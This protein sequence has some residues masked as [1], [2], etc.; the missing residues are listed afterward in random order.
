LEL[1]KKLA[2]GAAAAAAAATSAVD[3]IM[4]EEELFVCVFHMNNEANEQKINELD[5]LR[6]KLIEEER[7]QIKKQ[8]KPTFSQ[9]KC[10]MMVTK[11]VVKNVLRICLWVKTKKDF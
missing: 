9:S 6:Q 7:M 11:G 5:E 3:V 1:R 8:V 2:N 4:D 10:C